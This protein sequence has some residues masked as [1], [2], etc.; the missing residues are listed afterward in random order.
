[1]SFEPAGVEPRGGLDELSGG[2]GNRGRVPSEARAG[3]FIEAFGGETTTSMAAVL[4]RPPPGATC[5]AQLV[6]RRGAR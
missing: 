3:G 5:R 2:F 6:R 4:T 1:M